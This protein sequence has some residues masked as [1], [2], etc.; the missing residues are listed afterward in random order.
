MHD[1]P[2]VGARLLDHPGVVLEDP[3]GA[4]ARLQ[5]ARALA[6][7]GDVAKAKEAYEALFAMWKN[8]DDDLS[9]AKQAKAE[10]AALHVATPEPRNE[11]AHAAHAS[12]R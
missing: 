2:G 9:L 3:I 4:F 6:Q 12:P 11:D 10:Y 7:A 1:A 8:A 5:L